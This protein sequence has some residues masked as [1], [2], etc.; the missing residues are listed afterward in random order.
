MRVGIIGLGLIGGSLGLDLTAKGYEV[1]GVSRNPETC[2]KALRKG[3][4]ST[5]G[6]DFSLLKGCDMVVI[7]TP[8]EYILPTLKNLVPYLS[9]HTVVTDVGSVKESIVASAQEI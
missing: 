7:A 5:S 8:I 2:S 1:I 9:P 6:V 3:V 4:A